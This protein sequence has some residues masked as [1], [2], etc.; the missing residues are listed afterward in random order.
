MKKRVLSAVCAAAMLVSLVPTP[1]FAADGD[2]SFSLVLDAKDANGDG[3]VTA[4]EDV[5]LTVSLEGMD[6]ATAANGM[7][8][9]G[10]SLRVYFNNEVLE[11]A[12][13][14]SEESRYNATVTDLA[15]GFGNG[16]D[17][18]DNV[19]FGS[20]ELANKYGY[21]SL[22]T[23][24]SNDNVPEMALPAEKTAWFTWHFVGL[25]N[26]GAVE[27]NDL[28]DISCEP[29]VYGP[30]S[31]ADPSTN[32]SIAPTIRE[33]STL[34][35]DSIAP[36]VTLAGT[37]VADNASFYY[38]PVSI[39]VT[40]GG[41]GVAS[42]KLNGEAVE[43]NELTTGGTLVVTDNCGNAATVAITID[44]TAY[45]AAA[46]AIAALP[47]TIAYGDWATIDAAQA[48][49]D[50][51]TD[52][53][54]KEML[55]NAQEK[56]DAALEAWNAIDAK[57]TDIEEL[58]KAL[59]ETNALS[60]KDVDA[61]NQI[62]EAINAL[63]DQG[64]TTDDIT[65]YDT[66]RA[67]TEKLAAVRAEINAVKDLIDALP[68]ADKVGYGDEAAVNAAAE[69]LKTLLARYPEDVDTINSAVGADRLTTIQESLD[70]LLAEQ[71]A[72]VD[73]IANTTFNITMFED[74][75]AVIND[76][77]DDVDA[78]IARDA[79][80]TPEELAPLTKAEAALAELTKKSVAAHAAIAAL[81]AAENVLYTD[82]EAIA[83]AAAQMEELREVDTFTQ[84][85]QNIVAN[86]QQAIDDIKSQMGAA[87]D[88]IASL[89]GIN[90]DTVDAD[91][92]AAVLTVRDQIDALLGKGVTTEQI[93]GY[94]TYKRA[95]AAVQIWLDLID[96]VEENA[97]A[98][99]DAADITFDDE[100]DVAK[101]KETLARL[102][103]NGL[104]ELVD[105]DARERIAA[106]Q[107]ALSALADRRTALVEKI[108][109][110]K[111][112][113][114]LN[115]EDRT[116][117]ENLRAEVTELEELGTAFDA[118]ELKN[119]T[120]AEAA[121]AALEA[122]SK[123]AHA[124]LAALPARDEVLYTAREELDAIE[125]EV[126]ALADLGD[127]FTADETAMLREA[128]AGIAD[129]D[130]AVRTLADAM[131]ALKD[132]ADP[133]TPIQYADKGELEAMNAQMEA[134]EA[135]ACTVEDAIAVLA[136]TDEAY[137]G[138]YARYTAYGQAVAAM[139]QDIDT[140]N[141]EMAEALADWTYNE[142]EP[143]DAIRDKMDKAVAAYGIPTEKLAEIFPGYATSTEK[144]AAAKALLDE[145]SGKVADLPEEITLEDSDRVDEITALLDELKT[146]YGFTEE[147]LTE[148]LG[149]SY[150]TYQA[151]VDRLEELGK[152]AEPPA[153]T[154]TVTSASN[155]HDSD[156]SG[157]P[158]ATAVTIPQTSDSLN[159]QALVAL[160]AVSVCGMGLCLS[161]WRKKN[162]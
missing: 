47:E 78:M 19:A 142:T 50:K 155:S 139:L 77:R 68:E 59:P 129:I 23:N 8:F 34:K 92:I 84:K 48:A 74:D 111:L 70:N 2:Y 12:G 80:F 24:V 99:P 11:V 90:E 103:A 158:A 55:G 43:G 91:D 161:L 89:S 49:L 1:V 153:T 4:G 16:Y 146:N 125:T 123:A 46:D 66:Y 64:V 35:A 145:A 63:A 62:E 149:E 36:T 75:I 112:S 30:S 40:D 150:T 6:W 51:V 96:E 137:A 37:A 132:P 156:T 31:L 76:L 14:P 144:D 110:A 29:F 39:K 95:V 13:E 88:A 152:P 86:A 160:L 94:D 44:S 93:T 60:M 28:F 115:E 54:A 117:I 118:D 119:L 65:N 79:Q 108:A 33:D 3:Y 69:A 122:R 18:Y 52:A 85:E 154:T 81:P 53:T 82:S 87:A 97:A 98:L 38:Q 106:A 22:Q 105:A 140:L 71:Q 101:A 162:R 5:T 133:E 45:D 127:T 120:D 56:I 42:V 104:T 61:L 151:A 134:L 25:E 109:A 20:P 136:E 73:K 143:F 7:R 128:K 138:T 141:V 114:T 148:N 10:T 83:N 124:A 113:I 21:V 72:L 58:I 121:M 57:I 100:A 126:T 41:S 9:L 147:M 130:A 131:N 32:V 27:V 107:E 135:R 67:A 15:D 17:I 26:M 157:Q 102:E 116:A 159:L